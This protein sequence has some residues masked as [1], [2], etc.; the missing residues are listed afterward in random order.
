LANAKSKNGASNVEPAPVTVTA[1]PLASAPVLAGA[2]A[3]VLGLVAVVVAEHAPRASVM[4]AAAAA[5]MVLFRAWWGL[6]SCP[7]SWP[8]LVFL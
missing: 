1:A 5:L 4:I 2:D 6:W 3:G 8:A 7:L